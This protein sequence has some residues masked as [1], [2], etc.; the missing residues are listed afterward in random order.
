MTIKTIVLRSFTCFRKATSINTYDLDILLS[1]KDIFFN[2]AGNCQPISNRK[3]E[4]EDNKRLSKKNLYL[5]GT[6]QQ[7]RCYQFTM[8]ESINKIIG[9]MQWK[10]ALP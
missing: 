3:L 7:S 8:G 10:K 2:T 6:H 1:K 9:P 5:N 4:W